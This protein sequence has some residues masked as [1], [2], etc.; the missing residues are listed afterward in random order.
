MGLR[1]RLF[2]KRSKNKRN[3]S[4]TFNN[5]RYV[6]SDMKKEANQTSPWKVVAIVVG[7][8]AGLFFLF[9][10]LPLIVLFD[11]D[12]LTGNIALIPI[13]GVI[14]TDG[15]S[16]FGEQ[17]VS[18]Q[19]IVEFIEEAEENP[20]IQGI[21]LEINSPGGSAVASDEIGQAVKKTT[22]PVVAVIREMGTSGGY[23]VAS[24]AD[25]IIANRMSMTGSIGVIS[26]YLEF[27]EF[28]N[29][30]N[31]TYQRLVAGKHKDLGSPLKTLEPEEREIIQGKL[32]RIHQ[33]F[34]EEIAGNRNL[35]ME[36]VTELATGEFFLG[37]E[38]KE[39]G[40]I[41]QL[42]DRQQAE[43]YFIAQLGLTEVTYAEYRPPT[44]FFEALSGVISEYFF[45]IGQGIA[46][47]MIQTNN[48]P[49]LLS[50]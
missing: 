15:S 16:Y 26:S 23:W 28:L 11:G 17:T 27:G 8:L 24:T 19:N 30:Y 38:A 22:K 13:E 2:W 40:L 39:F 3:A 14:T 32:D 35:S 47:T 12:N 46:A 34:I 7:I 1:K 20:L 45:H 33:F 48:R 36:Y 29:Q 50:S 44:G 43:D 31:V 4:E 25:Q 18:S 9:I 6:Y 21:L 37:V 41:D 5:Q 10:V 42:G 49:L